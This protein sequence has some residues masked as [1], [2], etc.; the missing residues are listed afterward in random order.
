[1]HDLWPFTGGCH[2]P[3]GCDGYKSD[4]Y[5]CPQIKDNTKRLPF[6]ILKLKKKY[7]RQNLTFVT[8]S[9][10]LKT[11][12]EKSTL[13][14][15]CR[16]EH[17]PNSL[18]VDIFNARSKNSAKESLFLKTQGV[19]LLFGCQGH[20]EKRKGISYLVNALEICLQ[21]KRFQNL[22]KENK[23]NILTFGNPSKEIKKLRINTISLGYVY[24]DNHIADIY[25]VADVF[26]LPSLEDNLPNTMIESLACSTPVIAFNTGGIPEVVIH[27]KSGFLVELKNEEELAKQIMTL[28]FNGDL[29]REMGKYG[30]KMIENEYNLEVQAKRYYDLFKELINNSKKDKKKYNS[31]LEKDVYTDFRSKEIIVL[32]NK[33]NVDTIIKPVYEYI[34]FNSIT[35]KA[36]MD[37]LKHELKKAKRDMIKDHTKKNFKNLIKK[38]KWIK[39]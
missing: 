18:E 37:R 7:L 22:A 17:I 39:S 21:D 38:C 1:L 16:I 6:H 25:S 35:D 15:N 5:K 4:C 8:P 9:K 30:R 3:A 13:L 31:S 11:V 26:I 12:A 19:N 27:G 36:K 34:N 29:R 32:K 10:W 20:Y 14:K 2:Y 23:V 28:V 24:S 33:I